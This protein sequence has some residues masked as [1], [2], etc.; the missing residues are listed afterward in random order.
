MIP[1]RRKM[2]IITRWLLKMHSTCR[3]IFLLNTRAIVSLLEFFLPAAI[4]IY[5]YSTIYTVLLQLITAK[6]FFNIFFPSVPYISSPASFPR[7]RGNTVPLLEEAMAR[8]TCLY[9]LAS[10]LSLY[11]RCSG[12]MDLTSKAKE[13]CV[14]VCVHHAESSHGSWLQEHGSTSTRK[15]G[16]KEGRNWGTALGLSDQQ[17]ERVQLVVHE[18][19]QVETWRHQR[20]QQQQQQQQHQRVAS[21]LRLHELTVMMEK[22]FLLL[23]IIWQSGCMHACP[24]PPPLSYS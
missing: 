9:V 6:S 4:E 19:F 16:R 20:P 10:C 7:S 5:N 18:I 21:A 24:L 8:S 13:M 15:E 1:F 22:M 23:W 3:Y 2:F 17:K 11:L 12:L 14:C